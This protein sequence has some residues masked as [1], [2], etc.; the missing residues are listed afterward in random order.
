M[1]I[2]RW[3]LTEKYKNQLNDIDKYIAA[4][5]HNESSKDLPIHVKKDLFMALLNSC[6]DEYK[7]TGNKLYYKNRVLELHEEN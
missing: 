7:I 1:F 3:K 6:D 5:A 4:Q 2:N